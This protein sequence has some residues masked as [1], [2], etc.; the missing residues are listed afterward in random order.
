MR[1]LVSVATLVDDRIVETQ[2]GADNA[3]L[4]RMVTPSADLQLRDNIIHR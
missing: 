3:A 2:F 4:G 1:H